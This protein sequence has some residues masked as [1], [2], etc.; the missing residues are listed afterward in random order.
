MGDNIYYG[1]LLLQQSQ[2]KVNHIRKV[3][4]RHPYFNIIPSIHWKNDLEKAINI[5]KV[6]DIKLKYNIDY[7]GELAIWG[8][9][10]NAFMHFLKTS[11][12]YQY[13]VLLEDDVIIQSNFRKLINNHYI[14]S[15]YIKR[16]G[17]ARLGQYLVG[18]IYKRDYIK[19]ILLFIKKYGMLG[20][21]DLQLI[22]Y[23]YLKPYTLCVVDYNKSIR[24]ERLESIKLK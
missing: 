17:A 2:E 21:I 9:Y 14:L 13:F 8:S 5:F 22:K 15:G 4:K 3:T 11:K 20:P 6:N 23:N 19:T 18:S 12:K 24:S 1:I 7:I 16:V 10:I